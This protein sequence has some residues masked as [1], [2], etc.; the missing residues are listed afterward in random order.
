MENARKRSTGP[1]AH[2]PRV[3]A[4]KVT[5]EFTGRVH[6]IR[7]ADI[8]EYLVA[9]VKQHGGLTLKLVSPG[10][11]GVPDRIVL[12]KGGRISF[13][14]LKA[15][16]RK[17]TPLQESRIEQ[18]RSMGFPVWVVDNQMSVDRVAYLTCHGQVQTEEAE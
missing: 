16:M 2:T 5:S 11:A 9:K 12:G 3:R 13:V 6:H 18:L 4:R 17:P 10:M 7:E 1:N 8:E 15:P 14:E